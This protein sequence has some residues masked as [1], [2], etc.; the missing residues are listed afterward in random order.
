[1][2]QLADFKMGITKVKT[3]LVNYQELQSNFQ[4]I[5]QYKLQL[6]VKTMSLMFLTISSNLKCQRYMV[7]LYITVRTNYKMPIIKC[8]SVLRC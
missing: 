8:I 6:I 7:I 1:M 2:N 5:P 4:T 3:H